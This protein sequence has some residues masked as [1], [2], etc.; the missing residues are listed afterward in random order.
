MTI[1]GPEGAEIRYTTNGTVPTAE[2]NLYS[3]AI[4][5]ND[6]ATVKA[7]AIKNGI[8]SDTATKVFTKNGSNIGSEGFETGN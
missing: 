3:E 6:T 4:T 8:S 7:I 5:L 2:S 1:T